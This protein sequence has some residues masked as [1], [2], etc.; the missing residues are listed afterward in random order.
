MFVPA[1]AGD[2]FVAIRTRGDAAREFVRGLYVAQLHLREVPSTHDEV[3]VV[4]DE[5]GHREPAGEVDHTRT[6]RRFRIDGG[7]AIS[8]D[9]D[10]RRE[11][12]TRPDPAVGQDEQRLS[13]PR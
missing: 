12:V 7:N 2:P 13:S 3:H 8:F 9:D 6:R 10:A 4:V 11:R 1:A 5:A